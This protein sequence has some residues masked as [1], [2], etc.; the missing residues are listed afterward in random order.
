MHLNYKYSLRI[1]VTFFNYLKHKCNFNLV[2]YYPIAF[3]IDTLHFQAPTTTYRQV[4]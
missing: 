2:L 3:D 1:F 4:W